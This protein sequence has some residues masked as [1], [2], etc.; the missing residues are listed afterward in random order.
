MNFAG[1]PLP[2]TVVG[3]DPLRVAMAHDARDLA[4]VGPVLRYLVT[5]EDN[6][7]FGEEPVARTR[8]MVESVG[9]ELLRALDDVAQADRATPLFEALVSTPGLVEHCHVM[10]LEAQL[11]EQLSERGIDSLLPPL[12]QARIGAAD[13]VI[14]SL[15]MSL[16]AAQTRFLRRHQR[17]ELGL[18]E[19]P[20]DLLH[21]CITTAEA[22]LGSSAEAALAAIRA[23]YDERRGRLAILAQLGLGLGDAFAASLDPAQAGFALFATAISLVTGVVRDA[24][25][26]AAANGRPLRLAMLL[27]LAGLEPSARERAMLCLNP[28]ARLPRRWLE[29]GAE[30]AAELLGHGDGR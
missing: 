17:M 4:G 27:A 12:V 7:L 28:D 2:D 5:S 18:S 9:F 16:M 14:A 10:A 1:S 25:V 29:I 22:Q 13:P 8:G 19:L 11:T 6:G 15:A 24:V 30:E 21:G 23:N 20:V 26:L 3:A